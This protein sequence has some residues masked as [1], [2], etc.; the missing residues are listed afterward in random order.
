[1]AI[2]FYTA[3]FVLKTAARSAGTTRLFRVS[4]KA[5][6]KWSILKKKKKKPKPES[7][8]LISFSG[9]NIIPR[10]NRR[11]RPEHRDDPIGLPQWFYLK[12]HR[13]LPWFYRTFRILISICNLRSNFI[14]SMHDDY[15][16]RSVNTTHSNSVFLTYYCVDLADCLLAETK[17]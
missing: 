14:T 7:C 4:S 6:D 11:L 16:R 8:Y 12:N 17:P 10:V 9:D 13:S 1:M 5:N 2:L 3:I 15:V